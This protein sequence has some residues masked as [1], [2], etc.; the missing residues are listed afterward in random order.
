VKKKA[1]NNS[2]VSERRQRR[3]L[4]RS[5]GRSY[6]PAEEQVFRKQTLLLCLLL[7]VATFAIYVRVIEQPFTAYDDDIYVEHN[8]HVTAGLTWNT[9]TWA[10]RSTEQSN[11]HPLTWLS[12]ALDVEI[13]G[14]DPAGHHFTN[15]LFHV[16]NVLLLFLL[17]AWATGA[18]GRS[19]LVAA[20]FAAHP[21]NVES[22]AWIAER[23][24]VLSTFFFLLAVGAYGWY[25]LKPGLKRGAVVAGLLVLGLASKPMVIT[26]PFVLILLDFWPLRRI[27]GWTEPSSEHEIPQ[28]PISRL[29]LEKT[30]LLLL[31]AG[32]AAIT[33]VAQRL[34]VKPLAAFPFAVRLENA[35]YAYLLYVWKAVWPAALAPYYPH[36]GTSVRFWQAGLA[37]LFLVSLSAVVWWQRHARPY[38]VTG[39]L[40]FLGTLV[41]VIGLVQVGDQAMA[42]RYTYIPMIG[43]FVIAV[44]YASDLTDRFRIKLTERSAA[45]AV[46][47]LVLA[48]LTVHQIGYWQSPYTFWAH[49]LEVTKDNPVA[50]NNL[51]AVLM[52]MGR[53]NEALQH[54]KNV[55]RTHPTFSVSHLDVANILGGHNQIPEA[56]AE[57]AAAIQAASLN[58]GDLTNSQVFV[59]ANIKL[60][61]LYVQQGEYEKARQAYQ[62]ASRTGSPTVDAEINN[63]SRRLEAHPVA[64]DCLGLGMILQ[65]TGRKSEAI[66]AYQH[67]LELDPTLDEAWRSLQ[68]LQ[69]GT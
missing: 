22:V 53:E 1:R 6:P 67:A 21:L 54:F 2:T 14:L 5:Q 38:F 20:L 26:L 28:L 39:W 55:A 12:H 58:P 69:T 42:D 16:S 47:L 35:A 29:L 9:V 44:W 24:N 34:A 52:V 17:L 30:P 41:P 18:V 57:Y 10:L 68:A 61:T 15:L 40:W 8:E 66:V 46:L 43:I 32:S 19:F 56:M 11:W 51:A 25:A 13:H 60:G 36:P 27:S 3:A 45:A 65:Q 62:Q 4:A 37:S 49:S 48:G 64:V 31:S 59:V 23:K 33:L 50:E 7:A 63:L